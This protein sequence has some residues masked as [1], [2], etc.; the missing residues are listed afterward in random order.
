[1]KLR[2]LQT[3]CVRNMTASNTQRR[4]MTASNT[5]RIRIGSYNIL[6]VLIKLT[7]PHLFNTIYSGH[8]QVAVHYRFIYSLNMSFGRHDKVTHWWES[9]TTITNI[10]SMFTSYLFYTIHC[11]S[12]V[13]STDLS[14]YSQLEIWLCKKLRTI[15]NIQMYVTT[16][17]L[18]ALQ[19][20]CQAQI[21]G[22]FS[23]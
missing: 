16:V 14:P 4:D 8:S 22:H 18:S 15:Q 19:N 17:F 9:C 20:I 3:T 2:K 21:S 10:A 7:H 23:V 12:K 13:L 5:N 11:T 6:R 1:M